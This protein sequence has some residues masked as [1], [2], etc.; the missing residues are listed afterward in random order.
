M[1]SWRAMAADRSS[2]AVSG[3][4][5]RPARRG[6]TLI[7]LVV[8]VSIVSVM[9]GL[10][11]FAASRSQDRVSVTRSAAS[12]RARVERVRALTR[13]AGPRLGTARLV[14][15]PNCAGPGF[16]WVDIDPASG[17]VVLPVA[18]RYERDV[19][20]LHVDCELWDWG[21]LGGAEDEASFVFPTD[22]VRFAFSSNGRLIVSQATPTDDV[23]VQLRHDSSGADFPGFRVL[24]AGAIC[25]ASNPDPMDEAC[26]EGD[27]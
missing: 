12:L 10:A 8:V 3:M 19:D 21:G 16:L 17:D 14:P 15:G 9:A 24:P 22:T 1:Q 23:F 4:R 27:G 2:S 20:E 5:R 11:A 13:V 26:D 18:V 6:F 7:E 25:T